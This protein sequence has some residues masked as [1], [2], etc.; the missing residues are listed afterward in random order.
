MS[1]WDYIIVGGGSAGAVIAERLSRAPAV[2]VLVIEAGPDFRAP[3]IPA[4][5]RDSTMGMALGMG[6]ANDVVHPE[7]YWHG[8]TATRA[9][10]QQAFPYRRGRGLG[11]SSV[12]NGI[13]AMRGIASDFEQWERMGAT[14]W[15]PQAMLQGFINIEDDEKFGDQPYHGTGGPTPIYRESEAGWGGVDR[16]LLAAA[17][18]AGYGFEPD[19]NSPTS[20]GV[21]PF[22]MN[23]RH[24]LR[25]SANHAYIEPARERDNLTIIGETL[26]DRVVFDGDSAVGVVAADGSEYRTR[27]GGEVILCAGSTNSPTILMRS[28]IGP[29][30]QLSGLGIDLRVDAPVGQGGQ[31]H[32]V[33]FLD[34]PVT[35]EGQESAANR[36]TYLVLRYSSEVPGGQPNDVMIM[37]TNRNYWFGKPTAGLAVSLQQP[38]SRATMTLRSTDPHDDP[39]FELNL[40]SDERDFRRSAAGLELAAALVEHDAFQQ[41]ITGPPT[42][43]RD[44]GEI[45]AT[46]KDTMHLS[47]T[48]RMGSVGDPEAVVDPHC[49]VIGVDG[50]RVVDA[51]IMPTVA[52]ANTYLTV[53]AMAE[54]FLAKNPE[55]PQA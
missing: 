8:I 23:V 9:R 38:L 48:V 36:P 19:L 32:A 20:T 29:R 45:R 53:L 51:S 13:Y 4:G 52:S 47:S 10:G 17:T 34:L 41:I 50:L 16:A 7:Y 39:H 22:P 1:S 55:L 54:V 33:V 30:D 3:D 35:E 11:G 5:F 25:I 46:V 24:G 12:V 28:G 43:P 31:D 15:G 6:H 42:M 37:A 14:G 27:R 44:E 26:I 40:L 49:R 2:K 18:D 21:S